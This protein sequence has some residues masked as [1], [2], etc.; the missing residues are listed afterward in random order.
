MK[1]TKEFVDGTSMRVEVRYMMA[2]GVPSVVFCV[3]ER[4][5]VISQQLSAVAF[6]DEVLRREK[7]AAQCKAN[8]DS[9]VAPLLSRH[10]FKNV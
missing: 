10:G 6:A 3:V 7:F 4:S 5:G 8:F 1:F 2:S 9:D